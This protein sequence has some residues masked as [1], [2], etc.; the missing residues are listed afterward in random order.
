MIDPQRDIDRVL[1]LATRLDLRVSHMLE[2][3]V[4]ND[5]V[6]GGL[7]LAQRT[8][9]VYLVP[10][11]SDVDFDHLAAE[12]GN[13]VTAGQMRLRVLHTPGHTHHHVS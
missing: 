3:P 5:Y 7:D 4:H 13:V 11:G 12:D 9:A 6:S 2:T 8:G 1:D 10:S